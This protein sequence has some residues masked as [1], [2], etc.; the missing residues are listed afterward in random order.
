M[1]DLSLVRNRED[2]RRALIFSVYEKGRTIRHGPLCGARAGKTERG[3]VTVLR[4]SPIH[5]ALR[6]AAFHVVH[7]PE[8]PE[9]GFFV[10]GERHLSDAE[11]SEK[12]YLGTVHHLA[13][14]RRHPERDHNTFNCG[15]GSWEK[16]FAGSA[17]DAKC[18][19]RATGRGKC[20]RTTS[21]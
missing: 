6:E 13:Y 12:K 19:H 15:G 17:T 11:R 8:D 20:T 4:T 9:P 5:R 14:R 7:A 16:G 3:G 21:C 2:Q 10:E 18:A 1:H